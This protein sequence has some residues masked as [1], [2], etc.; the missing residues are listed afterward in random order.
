[1][2]DLDK[3]TAPDKRKAVRRKGKRGS[4][5]DNLCHWTA[6]DTDGGTVVFP[7]FK[8]PPDDLKRFEQGVANC[9]TTRAVLARMAISHV[10]QLPEAEQIALLQNYLKGT[11]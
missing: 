5:L 7:T 6:P 3:I 8:I 11:K 1:M 4:N 10:A 9:D 2:A